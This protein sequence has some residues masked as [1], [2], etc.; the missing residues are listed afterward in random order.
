MYTEDMELYHVLNRGVDKRNIYLDDNDRLRFIHDLY[1]FNSTC[2][3]EYPYRTIRSGDF[4]SPH[5]RE[6]IVDIH[7]WALMDN[8]YHLLL[9]ELIEGGLTLFL[10]KLNI[11]YAKFFNERYGRSGTLFQ[12]RTKKILITQEAHF[13]YILHYLHLNALDCLAGAEGWRE[14]SKSGITDL[15]KALC[16]LNTYR[17]SSYLDYAGKK[18]FPSILRTDLFQEKS[19]DYIKELQNY[20]RDAESLAPQFILE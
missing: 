17:W 7:G 1:E 2:P 15:K 6:K 9:S 18:N 4:V 13:L 19:G 5:L 16:Y 11:G 14:R 3:A 20:L 8:H 10:R 12:G